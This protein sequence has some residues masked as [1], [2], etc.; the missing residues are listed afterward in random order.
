ML[1]IFLYKFRTILVWLFHETQ[2]ISQ[3]GLKKLMGRLDLRLIVLKKVIGFNILKHLL[4]KQANR[5]EKLLQCVTHLI[6]PD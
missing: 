6:I 3:L 5:M 1:Y 4:N 2:A